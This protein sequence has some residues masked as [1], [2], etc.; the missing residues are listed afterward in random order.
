MTTGRINQ[1]SSKK[2]EQEHTKACEKQL[3]ERLFFVI[4]C[5]VLVFDKTLDKRMRH[6]G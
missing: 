3:R 1:I 5:V 2:R 4:S 6:R